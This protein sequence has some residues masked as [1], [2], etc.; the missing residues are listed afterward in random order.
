MQDTRLNQFFNAAT[1]QLEGWLNNPWRRISL[2]TISLLFGFF[3]GEVMAAVAGQTARW[4]ATVSGLLVVWVEIISRL[5]Y[6]GSDR[7]NRF[8]LDMANYLKVGF[9]YSLFLEAFKLGS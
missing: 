1:R 5:A 2:L 6:G 8:L 4:D 7:G 3:L 9:I